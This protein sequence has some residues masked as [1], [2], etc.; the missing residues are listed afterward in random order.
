MGLYL[1]SAFMMIV[2]IIIII[3]LMKLDHMIYSV[4]YPVTLQFLLPI[5]SGSFSGILF[6]M[7]SVVTVSKAETE[8]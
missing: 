2:T 8:T 6:M 1:I 3:S 7:C 4:T 5:R